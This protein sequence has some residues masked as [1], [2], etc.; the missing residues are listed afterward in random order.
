MDTIK[1][2]RTELSTQKKND[3]KMYLAFCNLA[4]WTRSN[5]ETASAQDLR[6]K[7]SVANTII[8][9]VNATAHIT[10]TYSQYDARVQVARDIRDRLSAQIAVSSL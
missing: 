7:R 8:S 6:Q 3:R 9:Y 10:E 1:R 2:L 4:H 5:I